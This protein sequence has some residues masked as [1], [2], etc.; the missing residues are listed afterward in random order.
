MMDTTAD[1]TLMLNYKCR[2]S[3]VTTINLTGDVA[4]VKEPPFKGNITGDLDDDMKTSTV[5]FTH[6][7]YSHDGLMLSTAPSHTGSILV[8]ALPSTLTLGGIPA[9]QWSSRKG[10][11][12]PSAST[13]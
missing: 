4:T 12:L 5:P 3:G 2:T 7:N 8:P 10:L 11:S 1:P 13:K 9:P 6:L